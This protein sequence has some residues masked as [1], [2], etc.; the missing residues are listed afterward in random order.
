MHVFAMNENKVLTKWLKSQ[1]SLFNF[2]LC[3][4]II[5]GIIS[6]LIIIVQ[7]WILA[8]IIQLLLININNASFIAFKG[9]LTTIS[10]LIIIKI[11]INYFID[12][13]NF[14][15]GCLIR[16]N[17]RAKV[18]DRLNELGPAWIHGK[19]AGSWSSILIEQIEDIHDFYARYMPQ[20][21][22]SVLVPMLIFTVVL[23]VN[24]VSGL[25]I[26]LTSPLIP[27]FMVLVGMGATKANKRNFSALARLSGCFLDMLRGID[28]IRLF[29]NYKNETEKIRIYTENFRN[30][31]MEVLRIAFL[32]SSVIEFFVSISIAVIAVYFF[33]SYLGELHFGNYGT[34]NVSIFSGFMVLLLANE[35]FKP[36]RDL[37][38]FYHAKAQAI[39][40]AE[41]IFN[42]LEC[43]N[44]KPQCGIEIIKDIGI[45]SIIARNLI[46]LAHDGSKIVGP[47][48][49]ILEAG[50]HVVIIGTSGAGKSSL[51]NLLL[52]FLPYRGS[53]LINGIELRCLLPQ[54][55]RERISWISQEPILLATTLRDNILLGCA[56]A[57][58][59]RLTQ[60]IN[61]SYV[62]EFL[63]KLPD[64]LDSN[65][66]EDA[67]MLSVGQAQRV[68]LARAILRKPDLLLLDEPT[69]SLD[70]HSE[71]LVMQTLKK[72]INRQTTIMVTHQLTNIKHF[73]KIWLM[74]DGKIVQLSSYSEIA[75][76]YDNLN[77]Y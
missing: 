50:Q 75:T 44:N 52:G 4:S 57:D 36:L 61:N 46:I 27:L 40:A 47:L 5:L 71:R 25:I 35:F 72:I 26:I 31:T 14:N 56:Q 41:S 51:I 38:T 30:R 43:N 70:I 33:F 48:D 54:L 49:F 55:W 22:L 64:G 8:N 13:V 45:I 60:A 1:I 29:G 23:Y 59:D 12:I 39:G 17:I 62:Q 21:Y 77:N 10:V 28:T 20:I 37:G 63:S 66:G 58:E 3:I 42:F 7:T 32:S 65:V 68:A 19:Q 9:S 18:I 11:I 53:I 74:L 16:R 2:W 34:T 15:S 6:G 69:A 24:W 73:D 67:N 76:V